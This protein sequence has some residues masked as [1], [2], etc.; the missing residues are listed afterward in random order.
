MD[1]DFYPTILILLAIAMAAV[2]FYALVVYVFSKSPAQKR[3]AKITAIMTAVSV[4]VIAV[5]HGYLTY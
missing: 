4:F 1:K 5:A 3:D 2:C